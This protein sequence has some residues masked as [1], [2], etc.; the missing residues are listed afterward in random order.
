[1]SEWLKTFG[2]LSKTVQAILALLGVGGVVGLFRVLAEFRDF[3]RRSRL[4]KPVD[5]N[6]PQVP[7]S[8]SIYGE[9]VGVE[10]WIRGREDQLKQLRAEIERSQLVFVYGPSGAGKST[11]LKLGVA[12]S[13]YSSRRW[14]P[15]Y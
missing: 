3:F 12:R 4:I 5:L 2:E 13:L 14:L 8:T 10:R 1:M 7:D 6:L 11:L 9:F 15:I